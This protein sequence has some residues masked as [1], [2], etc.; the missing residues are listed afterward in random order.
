MQGFRAA[1]PLFRLFF[2]ISTPGHDDFPTRSIVTTPRYGRRQVFCPS[3]QAALLSFAD[4]FLETKN[5]PSLENIRRLV[6]HWFLESV[7]TAFG[8]LHG[9][10]VGNPRNA[11]YKTK[12]KN[13]E[14]RRIYVLVR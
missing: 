7:R 10:G 8:I 13:H 14:N 6:Y 3:G 11:W 1:V 2:C 4:E 9:S 5:N 12:D